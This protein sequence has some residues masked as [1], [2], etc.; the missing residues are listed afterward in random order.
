MI[1]EAY[2]TRYT[3]S[4]NFRKLGRKRRCLVLSFHFVNLRI[5]A[6]MK[7]TTVI[8]L[9]MI[10]FASTRPMSN[11]MVNFM[12]TRARKP[13]TVVRLL[14]KIELMAASMALT[15]AVSSGSPFC[16][17]LENASSRNME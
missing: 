1:R 3:H 17:S 6:G 8:R 16:L 13:T 2:R 7:N 9:K 10:P 4:L 5:M 11:P 12:D 15:M 14:A